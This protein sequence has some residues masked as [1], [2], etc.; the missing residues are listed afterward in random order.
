MKNAAVTEVDKL[1]DTLYTMIG[2]AG[3]IITVYA[4]GMV[5]LSFKSENHDAVSKHVMQLC[6]G[7]VLISL[8][9]FMNS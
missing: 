3:L 1:L 2:Y 7:V 4:L 6:V 5:I 9:T 8:K